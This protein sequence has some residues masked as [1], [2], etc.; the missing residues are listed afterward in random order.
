MFGLGF[1]CSNNNCT[2]CN[3]VTGNR[4]LVD[5]INGNDLTA[6][7][8]GMSGAAAAPGCAFKTI[9]R[10]MQVIPANPPAGTKIILV[11]SPVSGLDR[12]RG[13]R[14]PPHHPAHQ[15]PADDAGR[16]D[17]DHR[18][19]R[20]RAGNPAGFRLLNNG[21]SIA[22]DPAA[23]LTLNGN[24]NVAGIAIQVAPTVGTNT[25]GVS[26]VSI[27]N[28]LGNSIT[29][30]NGT[31][32]I[33]GGVVIT[34]STNNALR[35]TGGVVNINNAAGT[36]TLFSGNQQHGIHVTGTGSVN[37]VG[38]PGAPV[39]SNNGTVVVS[40][41]NAAGIR[42]EQTVGGAGLV[43]SIDGVVAWGNS[44]RD[45]LVYGGTKLKLR[46]S[47]LGAGPTGVTIASLGASAAQNDISAIDLGTAAQPGR[48]Y[49]Q[50]PNGALGRHSNS[51]IC[52]QISGGQADRPYRR[53]AT[54]SPPAAT[55]ARSSTAR[56]EAARW[57]SPP[58]ATTASA[59]AKRRP[60]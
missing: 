21:S 54:S 41:N 59:S 29:V 56:P 26:N 51:G 27:V 46:N 20:P 52:V 7:G 3:N 45:L 55:R 8:S 16:A 23:P 40:F 5:P 15:R 32:T 38:T 28:T 57:A 60:R 25:V 47:V 17:F 42:L 9:T 50:V 19:R 30:T 2:Q 18:W 34:G 24:D 1:A 4:Y 37:V 58:T 43:N 35:V 36:Q 14:H 44:N 10:A 6:N 13:G 22:G 49:L 33:G 12:P 48:N 11:G 39:P 31:L 53:R